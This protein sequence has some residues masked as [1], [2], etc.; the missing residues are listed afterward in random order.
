MVDQPKC[1]LHNVFK[2][3]DYLFIFKYLS[4]DFVV[5]DFVAIIAS[6][7]LGEIAQAIFNGL[8]FLC[9]ATYSQLDFGLNFDRATFTNAFIYAVVTA[10]M[11]GV[12]LL[13]EN[14]TFEFL[15]FFQSEKFFNEISYNSKDF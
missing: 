12:I 5:P 13:M 15:H 2:F 7:I 11:L 8:R 4:Q 9:F 14:L 10:W 3:L 1:I 6:G